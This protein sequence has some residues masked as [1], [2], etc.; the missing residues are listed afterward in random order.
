MK[1]V[2]SDTLSAPAVPPPATGMIRFPCGACGEKLSVPEKY[3]GRK[4]ACPNCGSVNRVPGGS[5]LMHGGPLT[6]GPRPA[7]E[8]GSAAPTP[9]PARNAGP[10]IAERPDRW[11]RGPI[12]IEP[13]DEPDD[14]R[15]AAGLLRFFREGSDEEN[16]WVLGHR[17]QWDVD[18]R[19]LPT[20]AKVMVLL[21]GILA[22]VGVIWG[23]FYLLLKLVIAVNG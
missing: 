5:A 11:T 4:G 3:A 2:P 19:G 21:A 8:Q 20:F 6:A 17:K 12:Q 9:A 23:F 16:Q 7:A 14:A 22:L 1:H 10:E 18:K 15:A 13:P